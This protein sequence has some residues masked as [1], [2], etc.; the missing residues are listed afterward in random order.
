M[1][2]TE[3]DVAARVAVSE[4]AIPNINMITTRRMLTL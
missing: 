4:S 3:A 2:I 1:D